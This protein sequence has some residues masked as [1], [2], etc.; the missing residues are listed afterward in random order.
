MLITFLLGPC[1]QNLNFDSTGNL[2]DSGQNHVLGNYARYSDG[3]GDRW[4]Y[5]QN[6][7]YERKLWY[8]PSIGVS[9]VFYQ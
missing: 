6:S 2:A 3:P 9:Y 7:G 8:N 1:C 5:K 4:N